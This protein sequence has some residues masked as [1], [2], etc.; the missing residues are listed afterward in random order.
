MNSVPRFEASKYKVTNRQM[1]AFIENG[2][3]DKRQFWTE[4]GWEWKEFRQV[5]CVTR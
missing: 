5:R 1:L 4:E 2:G 3:Y